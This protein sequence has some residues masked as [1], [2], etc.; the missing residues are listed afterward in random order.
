MTSTHPVFGLQTLRTLSL[1]STLVSGLIFPVWSYQ[2]QKAKSLKWPEKDMEIF[3]MQYL[4]KIWLVMSCSIFL[5][6]CIV[7][8]MIGPESIAGWIAIENLF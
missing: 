1:T 3:N 7:Y 2:T 8:E 6:S 4:W 5:L